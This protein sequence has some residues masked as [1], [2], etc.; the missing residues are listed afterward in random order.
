[1]ARAS[2]LARDAVGE[3][4]EQELLKEGAEGAFA[5]ADE[6]VVGGGLEVVFGAV[7][8]VEAGELSLIHI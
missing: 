5:D 7:R 3:V 6:D 2:L 1:M 4:A 8:V